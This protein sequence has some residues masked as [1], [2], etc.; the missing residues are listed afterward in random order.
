MLRCVPQIQVP[1]AF[2]ETC[3]PKFRFLCAFTMAVQPLH[4]PYWLGTLSESISRLY[5]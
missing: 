2:A 1:V 5:T 4:E 3:T